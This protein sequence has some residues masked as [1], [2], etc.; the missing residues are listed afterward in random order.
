MSGFF[1]AQAAQS[2]SFTGT[3]PK[4]ISGAIFHP[5]RLKIELNL[6]LEPSQVLRGVTGRLVV[7]PVC[8]SLKTEHVPLLLQIWQYIRYMDSILAAFGAEPCLEKS[9]ST[10][11]LN[12]K[13]RTEF[14]ESSD[15]SRVWRASCAD[16]RKVVKILE[17]FIP[18]CFMHFCD[19]MLSLV[20]ACRL[21]LEVELC[22]LHVGLVQSSTDAELVIIL[23]EDVLVSLDRTLAGFTTLGGAPSPLSGTSASSAPTSPITRCPRRREHFVVHVGALS[24]DITSTELARAATLLEPVCFVLD[25]YE[26]HR[27]QPSSCKVSWMNLNI[28]SAL[29]ETMVSLYNDASKRAAS[30]QHCEPDTSGGT[31][32]SLRCFSPSAH[33]GSSPAARPVLQRQFSISSRQPQLS[34]WNLLGQDIAVTV[35]ETGGSSISEHISNESNGIVQMP[36]CGIRTSSAGDPRG[37]AVQLRMAEVPEVDVSLHLSAAAAIKSVA[38][39][40][41]Y[42]TSSSSIST[43]LRRLGS[44]FRCNSSETNTSTQSNLDMAMKMAAPPPP[45]SGQCWILVRTEVGSKLHELEVHISSVLFLENRTS[46]S[47]SVAP[48]GTSLENFME[49]PPKSR[50]RPVPVSWLAM[51]PDG[52]LPPTLWAGVS[53]EVKMPF[54]G[55]SGSSL[56][57]TAV[58]SGVSGSTDS[59]ERWTW[60]RS[61]RKRGMLQPLPLCSRQ[62]YSITQI[63]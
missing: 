56:S 16:I 1:A 18:E 4:S 42:L 44:K 22:A 3:P 12:C 47:I 30:M 45:L 49:L 17:E 62:Q 61:Q 57:M 5:C 39:K 11:S 41:R 52:K 6:A 34:V 27:H 38:V 53:D 40:P 9:S 55:S 43:S 25:L 32:V 46:V 35:V 28:S 24:V 29:I 15:S 37:W 60:M 51:G 2:A 10:G 20:C 50:P 48:Y 54:F 63:A 7:D 33:S 8:I 59:M 36:W 21:Q 13:A 31:P 19:Q 23:V 26:G 58:M 14:S